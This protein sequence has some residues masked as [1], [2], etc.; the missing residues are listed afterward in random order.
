M[1]ID[2]VLRLKAWFESY[3]RFFL[4]GEKPIDNPLLLKIEHADRV[5]DNICHLGRSVDLTDGQLCVAETISGDGFS[6][7]AFAG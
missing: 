2:Q 5:C 7:I 4:T 3:T 1:Q 6:T